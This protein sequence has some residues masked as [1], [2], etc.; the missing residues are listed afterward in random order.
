LEQ[1]R[2]NS[3]ELGDT[4]DATLEYTLYGYHN[5]EIHLPVENISAIS[6]GSQI[7]THID[8]LSFD[9]SLKRMKKMI[10]PK[11]V[12][13]SQNILGES[14][15]WNQDERALYWVDIEG[16]TIQRYWP[17]N[18]KS[19]TF[20]VGIKIGAIAF[21]E[22]GG[23]VVATDRGLGFWDP[24]YNKVEI[25]A[26]PENGKT[27]ARFNDGK[28]DRKGRFWIGTMTP[29][30]A[31][32]SLY[33]LDPDLTLNTLETGITVSNGIGWS[34]DNGTMYFTDSRKFVI[35]AYDFDLDAGNISNRRVLLNFSEYGGLPDGLTVDSEG[36]LWSAICFCGRIVRISPEG[37]IVL[38]FHLPVNLTTSITFGGK[39]YRDLYITTG[40][41]TLSEN[42]RKKN[43]PHAGD[44]F[45]ISPGVQG[46][47]EPKFSG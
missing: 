33:R 23:L 9:Y 46:L 44:L 40:W 4:F 12:L 14:P 3:S 29:E 18:G 47:P 20:Q 28:V 31:T 15:V 8:Q 7:N 1:V 25:F 30:G 27:G 36:Y 34:P 16:K 10:T 43:Q 2:N 26:N 19:E 21:R 22:K 39:D 6:F 37:R 45:H 42:E 5:F 38:E 13:P 24:E 35:Y 11:Q 32:S 41:I 17:E